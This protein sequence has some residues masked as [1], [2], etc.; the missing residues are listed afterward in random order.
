M[1]F[2]SD[3]TGVV[4]RS[5]SNIGLPTTMFCAI[6]RGD[7][8]NNINKNKN[9]NNK[10]KNKNR[11]TAHENCIATSDTEGTAKS[12]IPSSAAFCFTLFADMN[13]VTLQDHHLYE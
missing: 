3:S 12:S 4:V 5:S 13:I 2:P 8:S 7:S 10:N 1:N 6:D 9:K 11:N